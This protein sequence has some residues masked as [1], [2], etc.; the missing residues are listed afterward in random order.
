M[1]GTVSDT[2][3]LDHPWA[4]VYSFGM[5]HPALARTAGV[6][7]F[8]TSFDGL[9]DAIDSL[10]HV[11]A[12][13]TVLDV[14]CGS[15]IALRG[16]DPAAG[17]RYLACDISPAMLRRTRRAAERRGIAIETLEGD[18]AD[19]PLEDRSVDLTLSLTGLHCFPDPGAAVRE[20]ARVTADRIELTWLRSDAGLRYRPILVAGRAGGLV[21]PS[22]T[23]LEVTGWLRAAGFVS[24][25]VT[26]GAFAYLSARRP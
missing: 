7:G 14:P 12:G 4:H 6:V 16:V 20:I 13:G 26:E 10:A 23:V 25:A 1:T 24:Y 21:G 2:W 22:A 18:V 19:L 11:P 9:Y 3:R 17:L 5:G 8:G 15:G